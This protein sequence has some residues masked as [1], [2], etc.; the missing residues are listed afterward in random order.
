M[1]EEGSA[2]QE[3]GSGWL[4]RRR[5]TLLLVSLPVLA[6]AF[7]LIPL[8]DGLILG[9]VF[10]YI[11]RPIRDI[12]GSRR[13]LGS[14]VAAIWITI[15]ISIILALGALEIVNQAIWL[16]QNQGAIIAGI[17]E[18]S[19]QIEIPPPIYDLLTGSL[20]NVLGVATSV[21][22]GIPVFNYGKNLMLLILNL[23]LSIPVCYFL[24][25]DGE[26]FAESWFT[27]IPPERVADHRTYFNRIDRILSG[28]FL[29]SMYTA[30]MGGVISAV[31]FFSFGVPRPFALASLVFIAGLVP[32]LTA[33]AVIIPLSVYRYL[34]LGPMDGLLFFAV[35]SLLIYLPSELIIRPYLVSTRSS[36]HPLLVMLSF[37]GGALVA[38]IGGFFLAP[39]IMGIIV[40]VYQVRRE[41]IVQKRGP[42]PIEG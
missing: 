4:E 2:Q 15:P 27:M 9:T 28:I 24:L 11:G 33:W 42:A 16:T 31:V 30:I 13:R 3:G 7:F 6:V 39:A 25:S 18:F 37:L 38:G 22:A 10:A 32:I 26:S 21:A 41:E 5:W 14:A 40:G 35:A 20:Q 34:V 29:G 36:I 23:I 12:F 17:R 1:P 19:V 8:L